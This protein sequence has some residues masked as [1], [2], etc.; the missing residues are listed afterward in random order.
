MNIKVG[1]IPVLWAVLAC[2][3][4]A[5]AQ[6]AIAA[7]NSN[8]P[9]LQL[10]ISVPFEPTAFPSAGRTYLT[11]ELLLRN[12]TNSPLTVRR[13]EVL[14]AD[15]AAAAP[16][17]SFEAEQLD[18]SLQPIGV[19]M[20]AD[21]SSGDRRQLDG[22]RSAILFLSI[23]FNRGTRIPNNLRHRVLTANSAAEGAV[24][25]THHT[26][27]RTLGPPVKGSGWLAG[28][29]PSNDSYHRRGILVF[30]GRALID[31]RYAIDWM[32]IKD[33]ATVSGDSLDNHSYYAYDQEVLAIADG[34][35]IAAKDG[36]PE[37]IPRHEGFRPAVPITLE[38][39][40]GNTITLDLGGGQYAYYMHLQP[41]SLRV[42]AGDRVR[43]GQALARTG[44]SGDAR[45]PHLHLEVTTSPQLL[46]GEGVP[47]LID[48][49]RIESA[50]GSRELRTQELPLKDMLI[51][52]GP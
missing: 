35:V 1:I 39:L 8:W 10:E 45:E 3:A 30:G 26:D 32:R 15:N 2:V 51:D 47:Y 13:I 9:P 40:A 46:A 49:Y 11:Y 5:D 24:I 43:R 42:K 37:N 29:G 16:I 21:G 36:I 38:T 41:G 4:G 19:Q 6:P 33:G 34:S 23:A 25:G 22:G 20:P 28:A 52:F 48:K 50:D 31:R 17:A 18:T 44:N 27:L 12:F 14:D 7:V